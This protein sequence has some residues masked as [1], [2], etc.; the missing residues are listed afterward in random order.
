M[1]EQNGHRPSVTIHYAQTLDG[2]IAT[3]TGHSQW[4]SGEGSLVLAHQLRATHQAV[5][6]GLR[7]VIADNPHLTL[8]LTSGESPLRIVADS[9]LRLPLETN[10]LTD[11]AAPTL[12]ATTRRATEERIRAVRRCGAE[13]LVADEDCN[14]R[15]DLVDLLRLLGR[16]GIHS[17]LIEGGGTLITSVLRQRLVDRLVVCIAP[18]VIGAGIDAVGDLNIMRLSEAMTFTHASFSPA[19]E[20]VIFDGQLCCEPAIDG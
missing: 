7:T 15:V 16:R 17:I 3:R 12:I 1:V 19:G 13:V 9:S 2:R 6:V 5:M 10:L 4:I 14:G 8:R 18:K 11:G 20:D